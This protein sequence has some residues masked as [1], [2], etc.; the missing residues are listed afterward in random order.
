MRALLL[1]LLATGCNNIVGIKELTD[2]EVCLGTIRVCGEP[3]AGPLPIEAGLL[4]TDADPRCATATQIDGP[5]LCVVA[6]RSITVD[7]PVR[8][9]GSRQ[10]V[11][12]ASDSIVLGAGAVLDGTSRIGS[13]GP[14]ANDMAC[15]FA[16]PPV[17]D[18]TGS[19]GAGGSFGDVG[20]LG[21]LGIGAMAKAG[22]PAP[23]TTA[24]ALRGGCPGSAGSISGGSASPGGAS[25][26]AIYLLAKNTITIERTAI[27]H[28]SGA[29][30]GGGS[31]GGGGGGGGA[32]GMIVLDAAELAIDGDVVAQ[33]GGGGEGG[34]AIDDGAFGA[35][36]PMA[37]D[38]RAPGGAGGTTGGDGGDGASVMRAAMAGKPGTSGGGGGGGGG[39]A[40]IVIARGALAGGQRIT[41]PPRQ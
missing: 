13:R 7:G 21:G 28:A 6:A 17:S 14:D 31:G 19:G 35:V 33:G 11:L 10:L 26:G 24:T 20:G 4:D 23:I 29:G 9:F 1:G 8:P 15:P 39:G 40:G 41:P 2:P 30:G 16:T 18:T 27:V 36:G 12:L 34:T 5:E 25:G 38:A 32:G 37:Y 22:M 3:V